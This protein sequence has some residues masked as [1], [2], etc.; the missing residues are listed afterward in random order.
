MKLV[1]FEEAGRLKLG[2]RRESGIVDLAQA[3]RDLP[4]TWPEILSRFLLSDVERIVEAAP[5]GA[6]LP[7]EQVKLLPPIPFPPKIICIGLNYRA[8]AAELNMDL[9]EYPTV[10]VRF[11]GSLV[12]QGEALVRPQAS[13]QFDYEAELAVIIGKGGRHIA[14]A[15]ALGHI[16][17]YS[18]VNEGS[19]RDYQ[20][21]GMQ[22][23]V[24]KNFDR[25]GAM[26][27][28]IVTA[29]ELP[30]GGSGLRITTRLNGETVQNG[31]TDDLIF[32]VPD[33]IAYL[34]TA[35]TL[36]PGDIIVTGTPPGVGAGR[37]PPLWM[38]PGDVCEVEI[39]SIGCLRNPVVAEGA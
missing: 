34:S 37:K 5:A 25:S 29:D 20:F 23:T 3:S 9:P 35:M 31:N 39:E 33:L 14:A 24:G 22:W 15:D 21:Q 4:G 11:P 8:H 32:P 6:I 26:G 12:G 36:E 38:K 19:V 17:G 7:E 30:A 1:S 16:A 2:V 13:E 28:H 10:F 27:P 18:V